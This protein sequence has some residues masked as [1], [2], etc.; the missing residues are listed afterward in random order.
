M[1]EIT[2]TS[3][4]VRRKAGELKSLNRQLKQKIEQLE[5]RETVLNSMWD[6]QARDAFHERFRK[7]KAKMILFYD[8]IETYVAALLEIA[9]KY[10]KAE[11][12]NLLI[13]RGR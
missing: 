8:A 6:G 1:T 13:L 10:E 7:D 5:A 11:K 3:L 4:E 9:S 12:K 2:V